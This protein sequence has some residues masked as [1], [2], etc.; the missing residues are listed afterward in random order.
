MTGGWAQKL[1]RV[2]PDGWETRVENDVWW[3][4]W[5]RVKATR[6]CY[7]YPD[8]SCCNIVRVPLPRFCQ[9]LGAQALGETH[10]PGIC[11]PPT[12]LLVLFLS[13]SLLCPKLS[14]GTQEA[15][16]EAP[17]QLTTHSQ[18]ERQEQKPVGRSK[19][20]HDAGDAA[21]H[22]GTRADGIWCS[23]QPSEGGS[24]R[25][26]V[27]R[28]RRGQD[29]RRDRDRQGQKESGQAAPGAML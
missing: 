21:G 13:C 27:A 6:L 2:G 8:L 4:L 12:S 22:Q 14:L 5:V 16:T 23:V 20:A 17:T 9:I 15:V 7:V 29:R 19:D 3:D 25:R 18:K 28:G 10:K 11:F 26:L 1:G 24:L